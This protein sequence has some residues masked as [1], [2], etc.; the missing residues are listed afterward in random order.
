DLDDND[1]EKGLLGELKLWD[2][3]SLKEKAAYEGHGDIVFAAVFSPDGKKLASCS[4]DGTV[5]LWDLASGKELVTLEGH[6]RDLLSVALA[7]AGKSL[8]SGGMDASVRLWDPATGKAIRRLETKDSPVPALSFSP[9]GTLL[10][11]AIGAGEGQRRG[12]GG[13]GRPGNSAGVVL[14]EVATG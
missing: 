4:R 10:A 8:A 13:P 12:S 2:L 5:K 7:P 1:P 11:T 6:D 14:W 3:G 9:D